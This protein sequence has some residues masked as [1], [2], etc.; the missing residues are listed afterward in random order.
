MMGDDAP[1]ATRAAVTLGRFIDWID[2]F[3]GR[4]VQFRGIDDESQMWPLAVRSF[5]RT[6]GAPPGAHDDATFEAFRRYEE[7]LFTHFRREAAL[8]V[9]RSPSDDWQWLAMAQ[10]YGLPTRLLDW[11]LSPLV[12]LY[13]AASPGVH[14]GCRIYALDWGP[15]DG[16]DGVLDPS[17]C[18]AGPFQFGGDI[19]RFAPQVISKRMAEQQGSFTLQGNPLNDVH[20]VAGNRLHRLCYT[21]AERDEIVIDLFRLG[22]TASA[23]FRD[24][25]GLA[26][27]VRWIHEEYVPRMSARSRHD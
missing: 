2:R 22:I 25:P 18:A 5:F 13:F 4:V 12:A 10:Y 17:T 19:A 26:Q 24:L 8:L 21:P 6:R 23:L 3:R 15:V 16:E 1:R 7:R 9:E 27:T 11:S 20:E 14:R